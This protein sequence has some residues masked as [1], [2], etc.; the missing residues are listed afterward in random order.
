MIVPGSGSISKLIEKLGEREEF[1]EIIS[2][3]KATR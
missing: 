1:F 3:D 2:D